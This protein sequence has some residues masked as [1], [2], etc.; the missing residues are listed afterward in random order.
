MTIM[1]LLISVAGVALVAGVMRFGYVIAGR[2][3]P[4][5]PIALENERPLEQRRAA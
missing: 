5:Q 4:V 2:R 3:E 1:N